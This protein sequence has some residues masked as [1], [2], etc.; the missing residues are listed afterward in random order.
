VRGDGRSTCGARAGRHSTSTLPLALRLRFRRRNQVKAWN[1]RNGKPHNQ[2]RN[3]REVNPAAKITEPNIFFVPAPNYGTR[4]SCEL[5]YSFGS[6]IPEEKIP[7]Q[8]TRA[9]VLF[10][11]C[12]PVN[13]VSRLTHCS[14]PTPLLWVRLHHR[15]DSCSK[16]SQTHLTVPLLP[17][18]LACHISFCRRSLR[19]CHL[20]FQCKRSR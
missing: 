18:T 10:R 17:Q 16:Q 4:K 12:L 5:P 1:E 6:K 15:H 11:Q 2:R 3:Q 19:E 8:I 20:P 9:C 13:T 14:N 7:T